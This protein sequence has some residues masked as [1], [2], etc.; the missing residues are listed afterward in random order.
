MEKSRS[1]QAQAPHALLVDVLAD[2]K[3]T[4][5]QALINGNP[6]DFKIYMEELKSLDKVIRQQLLMS[7]NSAGNTPLLSALINGNTT[8]FKIFI[9]AVESLDDEIKEQVLTGVNKAK[10]RRLSDA[11]IASEPRHKDKGSI[12]QIIENEKDA[13]FN[14]LWKAL[15]HGDPENFRIYMGAVESLDDEIKQRLLKGKNKEYKD[16]ITPLYLALLNEDVN[17]KN[18][19]IYMGAVCSLDQGTK[20]KIL[21]D[22]NHG[23]TS[24]FFALQTGNPESFKIYMEAV[25]SLDYEI[26]EKLLVGIDDTGF[27]PLQLALLHGSP[28]NF[29]IY[30]EAVNALDQGT[31]QK[32]LVK[33]NDAGFT[34]LHF[35]LIHGT[36]KNFA[37]YMAAVCSL[38]QGT[39]QK[40]LASEKIGGFT[41]LHVALK[42]G[43]P[44]NITIYMRVLS[45]FNDE[46]KEQLNETIDVLEGG[47]KETSTSPASLFAQQK[48]SHKKGGA[49]QV[50]K[51][52]SETDRVMNKRAS[53]SNEVMKFKS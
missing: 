42:N 34:P 4:L 8:N 26:K 6:E 50:R 19:A 31:K 29:K 51:N 13:G 44:E 5:D 24:L 46:I 30:M 35:A 39:K 21:V 43:N 37:I 48:K 2:K 40:L 7:E 9:K 49:R 10:I 38:D 20:Q 28:E 45:A 33:A 17:L 16:G 53:S 14:Q 22:N 11:L 18:F 12:R 52:D 32:L 3:N 27:T 25:N 15:V 23:F 41:P 36:P 1:D 47:Y